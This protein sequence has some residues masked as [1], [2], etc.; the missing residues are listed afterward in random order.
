MYKSTLAGF[1]AA[2][3]MCS[4][5]V[6]AMA[7]ADGSVVS[8]RDAIAVAM[9]SNPEILQAQMNMEAIQAERKQAQGLFSPRVTL[10]ASAGARRLENTTRRNLGIANDWLYPLEASANAEWVGIDF[11]RRRGELLRQASRVDGA[12]LRVLERS[13]YVALQVA[14]QYL[15]ILLQQRVLAASQDNS[16]FHRSLVGDLSEGVKQGSISVADQQQ[17][18][19]RLQAALVREEEAAEALKDAQIT[20]RALTGLDIEQVVLPPGLTEALPP[21]ETEAISLVRTQ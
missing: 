21:S 4:A 20:L 13:Q 6:P 18:E 17:A 8:M 12:S 19:E 1:A 3:L 11:G 14:R 5:S 2:M 9:D 15:D 16:A 7:Q 10:D